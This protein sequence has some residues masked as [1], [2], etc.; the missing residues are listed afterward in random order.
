MP[1]KRF[2]ASFPLH[3]PKLTCGGHPAVEGSTGR[4]TA[5]VWNS[6][7]NARQPFV[8]KKISKNNKNACCDSKVF[9]V[10]C[11]Q[12]HLRRTL[13]IMG[14]NKTAFSSVHH[15]GPDAAPPA[16][17]QPCLGLPPRG[18]DADAA[19]QPVICSWQWVPHLKMPKMLPCRMPSVFQKRGQ[20]V[21]HFKITPQ[22]SNI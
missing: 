15:Q 7:E 6:T 14:P 13:S 17:P 4:V 22:A 5:G 19:C 2:W 9:P 12:Q 10:Q 8:K 18:E 20:N 1:N 21:S 11:E 16:Q 3:P